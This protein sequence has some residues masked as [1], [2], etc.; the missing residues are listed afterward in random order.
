MKNGKRG[1]IMFVIL[2]IVVFIIIFIGSAIF[3]LAYT[4]KWAKEYQVELTPDIGT[5]VTDLKYGDKTANKFDLYLPADST[6]DNYSLVIYLHAGG[7]TSGDKSDDQQMLSW[8]TSK[9]YVA[10]VIN[11]TLRTDENQASVLSQSLEVKEVMPVVVKAAKQYGYNIENMAISG[12]S[13]GG[14][15]AMLY[16]Y[17]DSETSPVP[18]KLLF[19]AVGPANFYAEDWTTYGL[20]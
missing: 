10:A 8:L 18:V 4:P 1:K 17:R 19:E 5:K 6:K 16:A 7:F 12:G 2:C 9:G 15:L 20:D 14:T 3:K 13:A 11:Y